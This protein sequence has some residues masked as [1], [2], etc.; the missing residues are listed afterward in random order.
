M[1]TVKICG[2]T[3]VE[4]AGAAVQAGADA[5]GLNFYKESKRCV[6][7]THAQAICA[8]VGDRALRVG[9]FVNHDTADIE[10]TMAACPLD[11]VQLHGDEPPEAVARVAHHPVVRAR[12]LDAKGVAAVAEDLACCLTAAGRAVDAVLIDAAA[13]GHY[14]GTG[15]TV[16]WP[17]LAGD[18]PWLGDTPLIL[19][20]GLT[21]DNVAEAIRV[22]RPRGVDVA[23]GVEVSPGVK[24]A[25]M[26]RDFVQA[27]QGA[28]AA[29]P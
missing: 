8:Y 10:R 25:T 22:V 7:P 19:A 14:G 9:V 27:A 29:L 24:D 3:S 12:R 26:V 21:P 5:I 23:S 11:V 1:F 17:D 20:G 16:A 2:L 18:R 4:D 28:F 6:A 13:P 15:Q